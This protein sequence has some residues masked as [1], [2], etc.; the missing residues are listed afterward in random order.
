MREKIAFRKGNSGD[1]NQIK[2]LTILAY[3]QFRNVISKE[4]FEAFE[5]NLRNENTYTELLKKASCFVCEYEGNI[6]GTAFLIPHGNPYK[7]FESDWAYIR[8]VGVHPGLQGNGIGKR[9]TQMCIEEARVLGEKTIALHTSE[10]QNA[11]RHI[12]EGLGFVKLKT[13]DLM[14][15][16]QYYLY[17]LKLHQQ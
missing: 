7:W 10:F 14:F 13:L 15:G 16:K 12:Y 6:V 5:E 9:L 17:T 3:L 8:L 4:N 1:I 2:D 11:A